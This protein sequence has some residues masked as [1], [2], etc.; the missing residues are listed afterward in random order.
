ME[1]ACWLAGWS[2]RGDRPKFHMITGISTGALIAPFAFL[3]PEYD[4]VLKKVYTTLHTKDL[5]IERSL[6]KIIRFTS[7]VDPS[8]IRKI[9]SEHLTIREIQ[10]IAA[11]HKKGRRLYIGT[12]NLDAKRPVIWNI[13]EIAATHP[14]ASL[15]LIYDIL[16]ASSSIPGAFPPV[17]IK[18]KANGQ[19]YDEMHVDGGVTTQVFLYPTGLDWSQI[20]KKLEAKG[21]PTVYIIRH[22]PSHPK[23]IN[24]KPGL[25]NIATN[26]IDSLIR[27]SGYGDMYRL[28]LKAND[29]K[30]DF[31]V[32]YVPDNFDYKATEPFHPVYMKKLY[33]LGYNQAIKGYAWHKK[34][35]GF[36]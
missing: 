10:K 27:S 2:Q 30:M 34:P 36:K 9:L 8:P 20:G 23:W 18:V 1:Q 16:I 15:D 7:L 12:T 5:I 3:G 32:A 14:E 6:F 35:P 25:L 24:V 21:K 31:N 28:F 11:E 26:S 17:Y 22:D 29:D 19:V 13:G 4:S 33:S